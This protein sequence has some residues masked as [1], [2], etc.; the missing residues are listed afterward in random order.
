MSYVSISYGVCAVFENYGVQ[1]S[2]NIHE[3]IRTCIWAGQHVFPR[4][5]DFSPSNQTYKL[6]SKVQVLVCRPKILEMIN[7]WIWFKIKI[8]KKKSL[9]TCKAVGQL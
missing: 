7:F 1:I 8:W 5:V 3:E 2:Q 6:R 4:W 9:Q